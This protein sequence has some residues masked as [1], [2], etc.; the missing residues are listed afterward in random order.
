MK[1]IFFLKEKL[2]RRLYTANNLNADLL[3]ILLT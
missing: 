3:F 1:I 2:D